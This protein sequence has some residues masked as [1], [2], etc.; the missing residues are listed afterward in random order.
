MGTYRVETEDGVFDVEL[1]DSTKESKTT[2]KQVDQPF[3]RGFV[4]S[5]VSRLINKISPE[6][7]KEWDLARQEFENRYP[8]TIQRQRNIGEFGQSVMAG[9]GAMSA[10]KSAM[11]ALASKSFL[12]RIGVSAIGGIAA[13]QPF[14]YENLQQ[15]A[16]GTG[17]SAI[18]GPVIG[19]TFGLAKRGIGK[20]IEI[21]K[22]PKALEGITKEINALNSL[23]SKGD[24]KSG[25]AKGLRILGNVQKSLTEEVSS[26]GKKSVQEL[27]EVFKKRNEFL[28]TAL[29]KESL[30]ESQLAKGKLRTVFSDMT[31]IYKTSLDK[32]ENDL[33]ARGQSFNK[34]D[35]LSM[36]AEAQENIELSGI[37]RDSKI[38]SL[39]DKAVEKVSGMSDDV[40]DLQSLKKFKNSFYDELSSGAQKG[41]SYYGENDHAI[42]E[43]LKSY[44]KIL[45][46]KAPELKVLNAEYAPM[47]N[48]RRWAM[49]NF[50]PFNVNEVER[51][52]KILE[53]VSKSGRVNQDYINYLKVLERGSGRFKGTG[54]IGE[55]TLKAGQQLSTVQKSF[56]SAK[57]KLLDQV[58]FKI[59]QIE[60]SFKPDISTIKKSGSEAMD[61]FLVRKERL[62]SLS[63]KKQELEKLKGYRKWLIISGAV[64]GLSIAPQVRKVAYPIAH[65]ISGGT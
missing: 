28:K 44:G 59:S 63:N 16:I 6:R 38:F 9:A 49:S 36:I 15:R 27:T 19:E 7:G 25:T 4:E 2:T 29:S 3:K 62:G 47:A 26:A 35:L 48:A 18:A 33:V 60:E 5:A 8:G 22:A 11:P 64:G 34:N 17:V 10:A 40:I 39:F 42:S 57:K 12:P 32:I 14:Q 46:T 58:E 55:E 45:E 13:A 54:K 1:D 23:P 31:K 56:N 21:F 51:G 52:M 24:I 41:T 20:A 43:F 30:N 61:D 50:K 53:N 65:V 37:P